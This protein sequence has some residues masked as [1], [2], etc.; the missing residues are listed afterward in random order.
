MRRSLAQTETSSK[1]VWTVLSRRLADATQLVNCSTAAGQQA[2]NSC[3]QGRDGVPESLFL[4]QQLAWYCRL[5]VCLSVMKF[6][7]ALRVGV[8]GWKLYQRVPR[9][10]LP[11]HFFGHFCCR[12]YRLLLLSRSDRGVNLYTWNRVSVFRINQLGGLSVNGGRPIR[13][14]SAGQLTELNLPMSIYVAGYPANYNRQAGAT[15]GFHGAIQR[16]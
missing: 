3:R 12:T 8:G 1:A 7:V 2:R 5:S 16:V 9:R 15:S 11:I 14:Q 10:A 13:G 4:P 6:I